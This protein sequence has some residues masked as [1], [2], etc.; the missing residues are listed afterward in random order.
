MALFIVFVYFSLMW[1]ESVVTMA[2]DLHVGMLY[3]HVH[4]YYLISHVLYMYVVV[5]NIR[6]CTYTYKYAGAIIAICV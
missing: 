3:V 2:Q 4:V 1:C 5:H 6:T